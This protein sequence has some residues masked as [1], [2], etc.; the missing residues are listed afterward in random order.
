MLKRTC[1][2]GVAAIAL[3]LTAAPVYAQ[4]AS[5]TATTP[6]A[7]SSSSSPSSSAAPATPSSPSSGGGVYDIPSSS[8]TP[9]VMENLAAQT[10]AA[11]DDLIGG[12][13]G[14]KAAPA[15]PSSSSDVFS[16]ADSDKPRWYD[17]NGNPF[18][19]RYFEAE[20]AAL[21]LALQRDP[22]L[23]P[24]HF[25]LHMS[26]MKSF[27]SC[28]KIHNPKHSVEFNESGIMTIKMEKFIVD[29]RDMPRYPHY[30]CNT[31][32]QQP[33]VYVNLSKDLLQEHNVKKIKF[34]VGE[35][36]EN[37]LV[38]LTDHYIQLTPET[39]RHPQDIANRF[40]PL[41][42]S[43]VSSTM[44]FWFYPEGTLILN[45]DGASKD[46]TLESRL[47][48]MARSKGLTPLTDIIPEH[49]TFRKQ[50]DR[51]YFVDSQGR[52]KIGDGELFDYIQADAMKFG[53][54]ADEPIKKNVA[55]FARKPGRYD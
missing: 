27:V 29:A 33:G 55:V 9:T 24:G 34:K 13:T 30:E 19:E 51:Y 28:L 2:Y 1:L 18:T 10:E 4:T 14:S 15:R 32:P 11:A 5:Y 7:Q 41:E 40:R 50:P 35:T 6:P 42:V 54:E 20:P 43:G 8:T 12:L 52:Y 47:T 25:V 16:P 31:T 45:A 38:K 23:P 21:L 22:H 44:K 48:D 36:S 37:Y 39:R 49:S 17:D 3:C 53:L 26:A 46:V